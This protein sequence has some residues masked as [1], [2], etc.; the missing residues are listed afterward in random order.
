MF[1]QQQKSLSAARYARGSLPP[2]RDPCSFA[3]S[4]I[5]ISMISRGYLCWLRR[6]CTWT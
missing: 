1:V 3:A 5:R 6:D 2:S 4:I